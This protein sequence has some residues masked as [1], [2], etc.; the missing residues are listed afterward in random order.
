MDE[1]EQA[2][3]LD[4]CPLEDV[5]CL[6]TTVKLS[7]VMADPTHRLDAAYWIKK[8][9]EED[10]PYCKH[11]THNNDMGG[12]LKKK[13]PFFGASIQAEDTCNEFKKADRDS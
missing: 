9:E 5:K 6:F 10:E 13:S 8:H 1:F 2:D 3:E 12:C 4:K 7:E 11:C